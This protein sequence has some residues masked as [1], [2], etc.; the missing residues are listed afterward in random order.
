MEGTRPAAR[1]AIIDRAEIWAA[2]A[3]VVIRACGFAAAGTWS[4][5]QRA[6]ADLAADPPE[7][8]I[9]AEALAHR[10][11]TLAASAEAPS[12]A[13]ILLVNPGQRPDDDRAFAFDG[14][15]VRDTSIEAACACLR[16]IAAGHAWIDPAVARS[17]PEIAQGRGQNWG[18]L[19]SRE[20]EIAGLASEGFSNKKIA[21]QLHLSDGTVKMHMHHIL[22][23]LHVASRTDLDRGH[24][25]L[26]PELVPSGE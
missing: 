6:H 26:A 4:D 12:P 14:L 5:P 8:V 9:V 13:V 18:C 19:S 1:V 10:Y 20:L 3:T 25:P 21:K 15:M 7:V 11:S 24:A 16:S 17:T 23:K 22:A 2:G